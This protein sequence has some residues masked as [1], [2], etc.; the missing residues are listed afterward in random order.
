MGHRSFAA[1]PSR[2]SEKP[3]R[4]PEKA[5]RKYHNSQVEIWDFITVSIFKRIKFV[6][7]KVL[8]SKTLL[9]SNIFHFK[10]SKFSEN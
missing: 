7:K 4:E 3:S 6:L 2:D 9:S 1:K 5:R 8:E 10:S